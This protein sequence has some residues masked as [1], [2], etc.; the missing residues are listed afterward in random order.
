MVIL[1]REENCND[2]RRLEE[3]R[4]SGRLRLI[5]NTLLFPWLLV[6]CPSDIV[7]DIVT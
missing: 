2:L 6:G 3:N 7:C 5:E 4:L 1:K